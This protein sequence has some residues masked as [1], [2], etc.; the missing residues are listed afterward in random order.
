MTHLVPMGL[1]RPASRDFFRDADPP[2]QLGGR[3]DAQ[4][5]SRHCRGDACIRGVSKFPSSGSNHAG[6]INRYP[7]GSAV[8]EF[9]PARCMCHA[10]GLRP[11][12]VRD[13]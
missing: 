1:A 2:M 10:P 6:R 12:R 9:N 8:R 4:I 13:A 3:T 5:V 11:R 7:S